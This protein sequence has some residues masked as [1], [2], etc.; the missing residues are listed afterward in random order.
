MCFSELLSYI[1]NYILVIP[2]VILFFGTSLILTF[3]TGF[4]QIRALP[5][6]LSLIFNGVRRKKEEKNVEGMTTFQAL[7][8]AMATTIGMGNVVSPSLAIMVGGPGALFWLIFYML[9]GSVLK[10]T[11]VTFALATRQ[12]LKDGFILGGPIQYLKEVSSF[13]SAWYGYLILICLI[14]WSS[15]QSNTLANIMAIEGVPHWLVGLSLSIFVITALLGGAK[16]V[17]VVASNL[18]PIMF[19]LYVLFSMSILLYNPLELWHAIQLMWKS[20]FSPAAAMGGF[21]GA[22]VLRAMKEGIFRGIFITE[23]GVGTSAIPHSLADT[24]RPTDQGILAMGSVLADTFLSALSGFLVL[25]TNVWSYG[26]Y[27]TTL[28]YEVFKLNSPGMGQ[29]VLLLSITLFV[30]TT[31]MGNSFNGMQNLG[32]LTKDN[33]VMMGLYIIFNSALIFLGSM[34]DMKL[35]WDI[36]DICIMFVAIPNL[37]G[38]LVLSFKRG[39]ILKVKS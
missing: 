23:S 2:S 30:L 3:K 4:I 18:V 36:I 27:R 25:V 37:I 34:L 24:K 14:S 38:L 33:K 17:G 28:V 32:V 13:L 35:L 29:Y 15:A 20:A 8:T 39:D 9:F 22:T 21:L 11:E 16:R 19:V 26:C 6:F 10:Y 5:R 12:Y 7:F 1:N 31:V